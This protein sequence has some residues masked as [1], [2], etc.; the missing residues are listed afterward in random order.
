MPEI[1]KTKNEHYVPQ[2]YLEK[3]TEDG[4]HIYVLDKHKQPAQR[5]YKTNI[6]N[7]ASETYFYDFH[8]DIQ[9]DHPNPQVIEH[10]FSE[11][12]SIFYDLR[13]NLLTIIYEKA[14]ITQDQK[15]AMAYFMALQFL[16]TPEYRRNF[17]DMMNKLATQVAQR[18]MPDA[19]KEKFDI[20]AILDESKIS[21]AHAM[22]MFPPGMLY[23]FVNAL[24]SHIWMLG[25]NE[26][27]EPIYTSDTPV[28]T[29]AH[30]AQR[31]G[32]GLASRGIEIAF[33][34]T[35][36]YILILKERTVFREQAKLDCKVTLLNSDE[37]RYY[38]WLQ[39]LRCYRQ[40]YCSS[41]DFNVAV[42]ACQ[43]F[44]DVCNPEQARNYVHIAHPSDRTLIHFQW[45]DPDRVKFEVH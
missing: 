15:L 11:I 13:D 39:V 25:V 35:K 26:T 23:E 14:S 41:S 22:M 31:G 29:K 18:V 12:E 43:K 3:F 17:I 1:Q 24:S 45:P 44:P 4:K 42:Q 40:V 6:R 5:V 37:I 16:R 34:L 32:I 8:P 10:L 19:L 27:K 28:V 21:L 9:Q 7:V 2:G 38:N 20:S 33:P 36:Q 30:S